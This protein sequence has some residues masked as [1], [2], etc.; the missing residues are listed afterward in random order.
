MIHGDTRAA[1]A[2]ILR[3]QV[4]LAGIIVSR[5]CGTF[6]KTCHHFNTVFIQHLYIIWTH[7]SLS[8]FSFHIRTYSFYK[9]D[10]QGTDVPVVIVNILAPFLYKKIALYI[11]YYIFVCSRFIHP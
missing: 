11:F 10:N 7:A 2:L 1:Y 6:S 4:P 5:E 3:M 9:E 8:F